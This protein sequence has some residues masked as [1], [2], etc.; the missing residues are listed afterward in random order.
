MEANRPMKWLELWNIQA[1]RF[2]GAYAAES[3]G[4]GE[5]TASRLKRGKNCMSQKGKGRAL[6]CHRIQQRGSAQTDGSSP[7]LW[8]NKQKLAEM[9]RGSGHKGYYPRVFKS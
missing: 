6:P 4:L 8:G 5:G 3:S 7:L 9:S 1:V 2:R